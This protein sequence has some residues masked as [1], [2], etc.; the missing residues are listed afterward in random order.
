MDAFWAAQKQACANPAAAPKPPEAVHRTPGSCG[1]A[2]YDAAVVGGTLGI[3]LAT[4][5]AVQG[6]R[7]AVI[8]RR[9]LEGRTQEW[10]I[11]RHELAN[12]VECGLL[13]SAELSSCI[14]SSWPS[15]QVH[16][17]G[18]E[19]VNCGGD[20]LDCGVSPRRLLEVLRRRFLE[21][22]G[23]ILEQHTFKSATVFDDG[24]SIQLL[25]SAAALEPG[26]VNRPMA[27]QPE[28]RGAL[29]S[30]SNGSSAQHMH[31]RGKRQRGS[32]PDTHPGWSPPNRIRSA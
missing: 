16:F 19:P 23:T 24:V 5:L 11:S 12:L 26:D 9:R 6:Q 17:H 15:V 7:V 29:P 14:V 2:E 25:P 18:S 28:Q 3:L 20:I 22:G 10:N 30:S 8:E 1:G 13:T 32:R 27:L 4:A 21:A 31:N